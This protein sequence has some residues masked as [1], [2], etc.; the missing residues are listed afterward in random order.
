MGKYSEEVN[1]VTSVLYFVSNNNSYRGTVVSFTNAHYGH[2]R[3]LTMPGRGVGMY[4]GW[5]TG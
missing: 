5:E 1:A 4:D 2:P 3:N